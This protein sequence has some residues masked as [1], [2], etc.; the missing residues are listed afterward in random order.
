MSK[1]KLQQL[2]GK[3]F[4]LCFWC[5][6]P[7]R[8]PT[9]DHVIPKSRGGYGLRGNTVA[10]CYRC[11]GAKSNRTPEEFIRMKLLE[12]KAF[13]QSEGFKRFGRGK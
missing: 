11:N 9:R 3:Q 8:Q 2:M 5:G 12:F 10:A 1:S 4:G 13:L 6:R 7:L